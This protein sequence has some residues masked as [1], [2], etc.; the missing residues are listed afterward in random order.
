MQSV[1][2][3]SK[4]DVKQN[5]IEIEQRLN[6]IQ[7]KK[8]EIDCKKQSIELKITEYTIKYNELYQS[9]NLNFEFIQTVKQQI[10]EL[11]KYNKKIDIHL[12]LINVEIKKEEEKKEQN[13]KELN[14]L[15]NAYDVIK[16]QD[17]KLKL[18]Q[19]NKKIDQIINDQISRL[20]VEG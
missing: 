11:F 1:I 12:T 15:K 20:S 9:D 19:Q 4:L 14:M 5:I 17:Q 13:I 10:D 18:K 3:L 6:E 7:I 8:S 16:K 2:E